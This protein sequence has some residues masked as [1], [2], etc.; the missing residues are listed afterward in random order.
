MHLFPDK[1]KRKKGTSFPNEEQE[2]KLAGASHDGNRC[3]M[4]NFNIPG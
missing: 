4:I 1:K 3:S 2:S